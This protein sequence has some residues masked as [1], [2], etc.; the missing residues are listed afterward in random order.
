MDWYIMVVSEI[1]RFLLKVVLVGKGVISSYKC[2]HSTLL[3]TVV[4]YKHLISL[5]IR[6]QALPAPLGVISANSVT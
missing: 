6:D 5:F 3:D 2:H 1:M 4:K